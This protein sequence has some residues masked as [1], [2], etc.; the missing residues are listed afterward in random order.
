MQDTAYRYRVLSVGLSG[1]RIRWGQSQ[2]AEHA[3]R[4]GFG[5]EGITLLCDLGSYGRG[6]ARPW[7]SGARPWGLDPARAPWHC[8]TAQARV[9]SLSNYRDARPPKEK[10]PA[11]V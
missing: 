8:G 7:A 3:R 9:L 4:I 6:A 5:G 10:A 1:H 2:V 11:E